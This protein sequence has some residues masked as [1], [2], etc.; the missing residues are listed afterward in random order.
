MM[1][2][3]VLVVILN[4]KLCYEIERLDCQ[5]STQNYLEVNKIKLKSLFFF[6]T[7][8]CLFAICCCFVSDTIQVKAIHVTAR[9]VIENSK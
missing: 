4:R 2:V 5:Q 6:F 3:N 7:N 9:T 1:P 8:I